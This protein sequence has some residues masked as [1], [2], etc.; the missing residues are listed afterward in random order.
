MR[1]RRL[2]V[3]QVRMKIPITPTHSLQVRAS[4]V[5]LLRVDSNGE[6]VILCMTPD[7]FSA[8]AEAVRAA[9]LQ[10][11]PVTVAQ[12]AEWRHNDRVA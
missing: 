3:L 12:A 4:C 11:W 10:T 9:E 5:D 7:E 2:P 8:F 6:T 1:A